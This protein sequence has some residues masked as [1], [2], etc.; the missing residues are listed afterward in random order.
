MGIICS[1]YEFGCQSDKL[2][3][4]RLCLVQGKLQRYARCPTQ[5]SNVFQ[6][7]VYMSLIKA[8]RQDAVKFSH[9][10]RDVAISG[11]DEI[12]ISFGLVT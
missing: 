2:K 4:T 7:V 3:Y 5:F 10:P 1:L 6:V 8:S 9:F 11:P 12:F